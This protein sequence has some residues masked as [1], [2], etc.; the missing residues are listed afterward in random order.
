MTK[1]NFTKLKNVLQHPCDRHTTLGLKYDEVMRNLLP[2]NDDYY[3]QQASGSVAVTLKIKPLIVKIN[4]IG[5]KKKS[6]LQ[7]TISFI[8]NLFEII[9]SSN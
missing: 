5:D 2:D 6:F 1:I 8:L 3:I 9:F 4:I 7:T